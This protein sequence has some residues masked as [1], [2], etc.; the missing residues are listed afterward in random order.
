MSVESL[1]NNRSLFPS[2][3]RGAENAFLVHAHVILYDQSL[4]KFVQ[5]AFDDFEMSFSCARCVSA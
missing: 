2:V 1:H 4:S 3:I 5:F